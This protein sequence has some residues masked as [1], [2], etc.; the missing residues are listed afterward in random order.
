M[1]DNLALLESGKMVYQ[2]TVDEVKKRF[3]VGYNLR[4]SMPVESSKEYIREIHELIMSI[5]P[6]SYI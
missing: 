1:A 4:I 6:G 5:V 3:G 2:G